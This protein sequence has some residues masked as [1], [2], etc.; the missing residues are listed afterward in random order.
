MEKRIEAR[1]KPKSIRLRKKK[2][3]FFFKS[4]C[5]S[6]RKN[7][8]FISPLCELECGAAN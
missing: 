7:I 3:L 8:R 1:K 4:V 5:N 2:L 6:N